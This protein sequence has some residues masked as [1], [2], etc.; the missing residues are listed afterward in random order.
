MSREVTCPL[1]IDRA[2]YNEAWIA[3]P[4][5]WLGRHMIAHDE[6]R[7]AAKEAVF[8]KHVV[9]VNFSICMALLDDWR[10]PDL[11]ANVREWDITSVP[12]PFMI[13]AANVVFPDYLGAFN[14]PKDFPPASLN[15]STET[16]L[17]GGTT[18]ETAP[19]V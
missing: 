18:A 7:D 16:A 3:L 11:P 10:I 12:I 2:G 6:A 17:A 13:W 14:V 19:A 15:G 5:E 4:D 1:S 8:S 9:L